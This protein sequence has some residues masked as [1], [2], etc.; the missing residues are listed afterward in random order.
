MLLFADFTVHSTHLLIIALACLVV[1]MG[2]KWYLRKDTA[3]EEYQRR[4]NKLVSI[5]RAHK[6]NKLGDMFECLVIKDWDGLVQKI[7]AMADLADEPE[8]F[9]KML[10]DAFKNQFPKILDHPEIG[11]FIREQ[12]DQ[13]NA[14]RKAKVEKIVAEAKAEALAAVK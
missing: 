5:L 12:I 13:W 11:P 4:V 3:L 6:L 9:M 10:A 7:F 1:A 2:I 8:A 14:S